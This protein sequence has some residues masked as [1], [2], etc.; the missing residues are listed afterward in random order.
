MVTVIVVNLYSHV[1]IRR[2]TKYQ[3]LYAIAASAY[4]EAISL[5]ELFSIQAAVLLFLKCQL[6]LLVVCYRYVPNELFH[7]I[8][9][10]MDKLGSYSFGKK[11]I[12]HR[13][14]TECGCGMI[15]NTDSETIVAVNLRSVEGVDVNALQVKHWDGL[16][17]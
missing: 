12:R 10:D 9:G 5:C 3:L 6:I 1:S 14:C 16:S 13:F 4:R 8:E 15:A 2:W 11:R 17:K 7:V